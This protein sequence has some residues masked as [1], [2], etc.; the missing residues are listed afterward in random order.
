MKLISL[1]KEAKDEE[2]SAGD[3]YTGGFLDKGEIDLM[4]QP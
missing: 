2:T 1:L 4:L 3:V